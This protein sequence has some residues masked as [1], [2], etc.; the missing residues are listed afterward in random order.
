ML[1][2]DHVCKRESK[3]ARAF[4]LPA[5]DGACASTGKCSQAIP[6]G[7][8]GQEHLLNFV[9][10]PAV[11][12]LLP[13]LLER[14]EAITHSGLASSSPIIVHQQRQAPIVPSC[15]PEAGEDQEKQL[16]EEGRGEVKGFATGS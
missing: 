4:P 14:P 3:L 6:T 2:P 7:K 12:D 9:S 15:F 1:S 8:E 10:Y 5:A 13:I 11:P 16:E